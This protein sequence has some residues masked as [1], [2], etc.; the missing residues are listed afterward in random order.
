V[1]FA[2]ILDTYIRLHQQ[3]GVHE[4]DP[5]CVTLITK[6]R[7]SSRL[8]KLN[9]AALQGQGLSQIT[10]LGHSD[11][12]DPEYPHDSGADNEY[13]EHDDAAAHEQEQQPDLTEGAEG[14]H[15]EEAYADYNVLESHDHAQEGADNG[16]YDSAVSNLQGLDGADDQSHGSALDPQADISF[17]NRAE[18]KGT[19][20]V[21][22]S[23]SKEQAVAKS[24]HKEAVQE[25]R[26][27]VLEEEDLIDYSDDEEDPEQTQVEDSVS[28]PS[29]GSST[30][31][32]DLA[33]TPK[34]S[35]DPGTE[36]DANHLED[37]ADDL[38]EF[39][40]GAEDQDAV[41]WEDHLD[42]AADP[43]Q[44]RVEGHGEDDAQDQ[45]FERELEQELE[46]ELENEAEEKGENGLEAD[47]EQP[48][49]HEY[50]GVLSQE[51]DEYVEGFDAQN[52]VDVDDQYQYNADIENQVEAHEGQELYD[53]AQGEGATEGAGNAEGQDE[54]DFDD[55]E[56]GD[57][58]YPEFNDN[59]GD[60]A[61]KAVET[62]KKNA[63][64]E[65]AG[66]DSDSINYDDDDESPPEPT[67]KVPEVSGY[68]PTE[69]TPNKRSLDDEEVDFQDAQKRTRLD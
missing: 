6:T 56:H 51:Q 34:A 31:Q 10:F 58:D 7:F 42:E 24:E 27:S 49:G 41:T 12:D 69:S 21:D 47:L 23:V 48:H 33:Q 26:V 57:F 68:R 22:I 64:H 16:T 38:A 2:H 63:V 32:G 54:L 1:S 50:N 17:E 15:H 14:E 66:H 46:R 25:A 35:V 43:S 40:F 62:P 18:K 59:V 61:V 5:L 4:P 8:N 28:G 55:N 37:G 11:E 20:K 30:V 29:S 45:D 39:D 53:E 52:A 9:A 60:E 65:D 36:N 67:A 13:A 3:D 44:P 19:S